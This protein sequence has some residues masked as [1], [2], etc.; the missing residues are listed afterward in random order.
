MS[1]DGG[2][3]VDDLVELVRLRRMVRL[4]RLHA[5]FPLLTDDELARLVADATEAGRIRPM[6]G[7][8][9]ETQCTVTVLVWR[10]PR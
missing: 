10:K 8:D 1:A 9:P 3:P 5:S 7:R 4:D 2:R 6:F